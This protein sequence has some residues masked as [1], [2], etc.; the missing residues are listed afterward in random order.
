MS[1]LGHVDDV[2]VTKLRNPA[3]KLSLAL[4]TPGSI[5]ALSFVVFL[6][7]GKADDTLESGHCLLWMWSNF[8]DAHPS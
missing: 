5:T 3:G 7:G 8:F 1:L 6:C 4:C 2:K